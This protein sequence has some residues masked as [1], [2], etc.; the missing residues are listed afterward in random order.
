M[1]VTSTQLLALVDQDGNVNL[2][3]VREYANAE[4]DNTSTQ[5]AMT[6]VVDRPKAPLTRRAI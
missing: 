5:D 6:G 3:N 2:A 4:G 1:P